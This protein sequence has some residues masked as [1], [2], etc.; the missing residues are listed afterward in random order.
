MNLEDF[1]LR[2]L[3]VLNLAGN[4]LKKLE[5]GCLGNLTSLKALRLDNNRLSDLNGVVSGFLIS[6][7]ST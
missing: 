2:N 7:G 5:P 1:D 3:R 6:F 4:T